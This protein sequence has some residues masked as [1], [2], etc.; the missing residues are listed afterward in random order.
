[1]FSYQ[2]W[3]ASQVKVVLKPPECLLN[4]S[5]TSAQV[6]GNMAN[7]RAGMLSSGTTGHQRAINATINGESGAITIEAI[8]DL[9]FQC[10]SQFTTRDG[11]GR[12]N[13]D[14]GSAIGIYEQGGPIFN[15]LTAGNFKVFLNTPLFYTYSVLQKK[16]I[17]V[18]FHLLKA[19]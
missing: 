6:A 19:S 13:H 2:Q 11:Y 18:L 16:P 17:L 3:K 7:Q 9:P 4:A 5:R 15:G 8:I 10:E 14:N 1:M 12:I